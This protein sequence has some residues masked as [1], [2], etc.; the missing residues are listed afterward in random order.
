MNISGTSWLKES[1]RRPLSNADMHTDGDTMCGYLLS[2]PSRPL[3]A[4]LA[5]S[6]LRLLQVPTA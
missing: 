6:S 3:S 1:A 5:Q 4:F 2:P